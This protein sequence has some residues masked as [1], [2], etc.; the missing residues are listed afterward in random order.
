MAIANKFA[1]LLTPNSRVSHRERAAFSSDSER[2]SAGYACNINLITTPEGRRKPA[3]F[4]FL[5]VLFF[6]LAS[7][8]RK[9]KST[10]SPLAEHTKMRYTHE[11]GVRCEKVI[12]RNILA[13][14]SAG[15]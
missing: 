12:Y 13:H 5:L 9:K 11:N 6:F 10:S 2:K 14:A 7:Q 1:L 3:C 15:L 8:I 4:L